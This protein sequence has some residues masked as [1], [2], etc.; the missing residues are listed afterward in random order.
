MRS[1]VANSRG[2]LAGVV[3][4]SASLGAFISHWEGTEFT[5]YRDIGGVWTVCDG[6]TGKHVIPG[7]VYTRSECRALRDGAIEQHGRALLACTTRPI[8]QPVYEALT[9]WAFN[10][11]ASAACNSTLVRQ[12]N[13]GEP[14]VVFCPQLLRWNQAG[15]KPVQGLTNRREAE[16]KVC[17]S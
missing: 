17:L 9:S 7:K 6:I 8:T 13:A 12:L 16:L 1:P 15:G 3:L 10:V 11:G 14:T 5:P 4:V 2:P